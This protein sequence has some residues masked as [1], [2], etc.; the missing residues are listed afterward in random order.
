MIFGTAVTAATAGRPDVNLAAINDDTD[1]ADD[2][3]L[4]IDNTNNLVK[5]NITAVSD[6]TTAATN[7]EAAYDGT[8]YVGGTTLQAV[9]VQSIDGNAESALALKP[10]AMPR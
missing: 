7:L 9:D 3:G 1:D 10:C 6:D 8:G 2:L 4:A 5:S